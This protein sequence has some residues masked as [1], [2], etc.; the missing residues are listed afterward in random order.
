MLSYRL[1][2][3]KWLSSYIQYVLFLTKP[4]FLFLASKAFLAKKAN[5]SFEKYIE[6]I[7]NIITALKLKTN[8][9]ILQI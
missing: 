7:N 8:A 6:I 5:I 4:N 1:G 9:T 2:A 3:V